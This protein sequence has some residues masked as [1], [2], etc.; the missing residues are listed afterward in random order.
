MQHLH[1]LDVVSHLMIYESRVLVICDIMLIYLKL[2]L[3]QFKLVSPS[4]YVGDVSDLPILLFLFPKC[5]DYRH[6]PSCLVILHCYKHVQ[7]LA[8]TCISRS[9]YAVSSINFMLIFL[10]MTRLFSKA[11]VL[12]MAMNGNQHKTV[13]ALKH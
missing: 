5:W 12:R 9:R 1:S 13:N 10:G 2:G 3:M 6:C 4:H 8:Q 7:V 11:I